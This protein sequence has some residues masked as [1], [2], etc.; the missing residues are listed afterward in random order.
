MK[1]VFSAYAKQELNDMVRYLE[2]DQSH[3]E[4]R[5]NPREVSGLD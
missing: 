2:R 4:T 1:V 5:Q 3:G